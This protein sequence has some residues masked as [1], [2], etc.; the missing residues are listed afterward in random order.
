VRHCGDPAGFPG[1]RKIVLKIT[2]HILP[3]S[4]MSRE[5]MKWGRLHVERN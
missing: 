3:K 4:A 1:V 2:T 5:V